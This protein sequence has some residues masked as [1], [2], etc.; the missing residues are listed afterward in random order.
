MTRQVHQQRSTDRRDAILEAARSILATQ[1]IRGVSHRRV[2]DQA[3]VSVG[4]VGYY[5]SS[6]ETLL[7]ECL[8]ADERDRQSHADTALRSASPELDEADIG[9]LVVT[10]IWGGRTASLVG[11]VW[12]AMDGVRESEALR[13]HARKGRQALDADLRALLA[14]CGYPQTHASFVLMVAN[15]SI[16]NSGVE[17]EIETAFADAARAVADLLRYL[18]RAPRHGLM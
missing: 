8:G 11:R 16:V 3:G 13:G 4:S 1:G 10:T 14:A 5:F 6:R 7:I 2:A 17:G 9:A 12:V 15:G 18:G